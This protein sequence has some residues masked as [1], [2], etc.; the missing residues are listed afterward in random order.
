MSYSKEHTT[1]T[2]HFTDTE[3]D[4]ITKKL[5]EW[6]YEWSTNTVCGD[7]CGMYADYIY[8]NGIGGQWD[9]KHQKEMIKYMKEN[10]ID[11]AVDEDHEYSDKSGFHYGYTI[12]ADP[13]EFD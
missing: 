3:R 13:K 10:N 12:S 6:G 9:V 11:G 5:E 1:I 8:V 4:L 2:Y 7:H